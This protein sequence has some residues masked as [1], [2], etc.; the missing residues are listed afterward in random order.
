MAKNVTFS[1][2]EQLLDNRDKM[3][4]YLLRCIVNTPCIVYLFAVLQE[5]ARAKT[6]KF[7]LKVKASLKSFMNIPKPNAQMSTN[8]VSMLKSTIEEKLNRKF[9]WD[10]RCVLG[11]LLL[12]TFQKGVIMLFVTW[13]IDFW[14]SGKKPPSLE[15]GLDEPG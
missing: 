3:T 10:T 14:S 11:F 7:L 13:V 15:F 2:G 1:L 8:E 12:I 5:Y 6:P 4:Q 9:F